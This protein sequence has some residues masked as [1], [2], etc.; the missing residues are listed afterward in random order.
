MLLK[1]RECC[2][3]EIGRSNA[4]R[5]AGLDAKEAIRGAERIGNPHKIAYTN[6]LIYFSLAIACF[7]Q[8]R[9]IDNFLHFSDTVLILCGCVGGQREHHKDG[10]DNAVTHNFLH[11]LIVTRMGRDASLRHRALAPRTRPRVFAQERQITL[12]NQAILP[13]ST[14]ATGKVR[15]MSD[16]RKVKYFLAVSAP[17]STDDW[18][19]QAESDTPFGAMNE[20]DL[21]HVDQVEG[22]AVSNVSGRIG[23]IEHSFY[24]TTETTLVQQ[25]RVFL[26]KDDWRENGT[27]HR[28][29]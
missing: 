20:G 12:K 4:I 10:E 22:F 8:Q 13:I 6:A 28:L 14:L 3:P 19:F 15:A 29:G 2:L 26:L 23:R 18:L 25:R 17:D 7:A 9:N 1:F 11:F 27:I 16:T 21:F 5:H 24:G